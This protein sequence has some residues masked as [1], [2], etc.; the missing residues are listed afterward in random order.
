MKA[1]RKFLPQVF[2]AGGQKADPKGT[3]K[4]E[5]QKGK[6]GNIA[7]YIKGKAGVIPIAGVPVSG[8]GQAG[9]KLQ[10]ASQNARKEKCLNWMGGK[11][12]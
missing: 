11:T 1:F 3:G 2:E 6:K 10:K 12:V 7:A 9:N 5:A 4:A 8:Q